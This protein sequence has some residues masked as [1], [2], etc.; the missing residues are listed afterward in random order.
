MMNW[1]QFPLILLAFFGFPLLCR[2]QIPGSYWA[3]AE[4]D[5]AARPASD[6][7]TTD[8]DGLL[9]LRRSGNLLNQ[10]SRVL[11]LKNPLSVLFSFVKGSSIFWRPPPQHFIFQPSL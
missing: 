2:T 7:R 1:I 3:I 6:I 10:D 9:D 11:Q 5:I 4:N 8:R